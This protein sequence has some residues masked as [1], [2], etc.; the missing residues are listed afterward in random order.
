MKVWVEVAL[1]GPWSR[2]R[3]PRMPLTVDELIA[4]GVAC[5]KAGA[6]IV[7]LHAYDPQ[8]GRQNDD[9]NVYA[10]VIEGI[11]AQ[12]D[13]IVYP[14]LPFIGGR[15]AFVAG[16]V[17]ARYAAVED[18]ARKGLLEWGVVDPGSVNLVTFAEGKAGS[19]GSTYLNPGEHVRRGL[20]LAVLHN[21]VPSF[22]IY[23]PGF[24]RLGASFCASTPG[25]PP[26]IYRFMF[27]DLF[28]FGLEPSNASIDVY[29]DMLEKYAPGHHWM[30]AGLGIDIR[31]LLPHAIRRG[32]HIRVGLEDAPFGSDRS[33]V[34]WVAD[35]VDMVG[36]AGAEPATA[37]DIRAQLA[38]P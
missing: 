34:E 8:T 9:P 14:T 2:D 7:H 23:E 10:A 6:A 18:L 25:C 31:P 19:A 29:C 28:T 30:V 1:N 37:R 24:L 27:S 35:A 21:Y 26:P 22:A 13:A 3:Q 5:V 12:V 32:G 11:R 16:A 4:E 33:N 36:R 38:R 20:D 15:D 17:D